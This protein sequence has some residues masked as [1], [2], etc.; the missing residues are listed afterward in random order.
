VKQ[1]VRAEPGMVLSYAYLW[2]EE[3]QKGIKEGRKDRPSAVIAINSQVGPS[4]LVY[5]VPITH[6][7]PQREGE[8]LK[9]PQEIKLRLGLD[10]EPAWVDV[11]E[12]NAFAWSG[13]DLRPTRRG[14][15]NPTCL[16]G[17]LPSRFLA[18]V[19]KAIHQ[20]RA[21]HKLKIVPR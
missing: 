11:T 4:D 7:P 21:E 17:Y 6:S 9:I 10:D 16:Y 14:D 18:K 5:V 8:K 19:Q 12:I 1:P 20:I 15:Q 3:H 2:F 13:F